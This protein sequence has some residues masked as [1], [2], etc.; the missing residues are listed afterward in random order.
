LNREGQPGSPH[1]HKSTLWDLFVPE[2]GAADSC[3][4]GGEFELSVE[5]VNRVP[6]GTLEFRYCEE[7]DRRRGLPK[8]RPEAG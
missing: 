7:S 6:A 1:T 4:G 2:G 8:S 5:I 3:L